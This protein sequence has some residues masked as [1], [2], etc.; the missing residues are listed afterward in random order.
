MNTDADTSPAPPAARRWVTLYCYVAALIGLGLAVIG[1]VTLL[2]GVRYAVL[3]EVGLAT[4]D[5]SYLSHVEPTAMPTDA[6]LAEAREQAVGDRRERGISGMI[7]GA[8]MAG[9]GAPLLVW[10]L[11]RARRYVAQAVV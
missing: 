3:P 5:Y 7:D 2:F 4:T 9:V 6:Q 8:I 11:R 10:H 1:I